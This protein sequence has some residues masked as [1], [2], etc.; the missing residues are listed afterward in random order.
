MTGSYGR[1]PMREEFARARSSYDDRPMSSGYGGPSSYSSSSYGS[2]YSSSSMGPRPPPRPFESRYGGGGGYGSGYG[3]GY[4]SSYGG[5]YGS[6]ACSPHRETFWRRAHLPSDYPSRYGS[7]MYGSGYGGGGMYGGSMYGGGG[8][9]NPYSRDPKYLM[10]EP[11]FPNAIET[12]FGWVNDFGRIV[13]TF[14]R[15]SWLLDMN[16]ET[17][18]ASSSHVLVILLGFTSSQIRLL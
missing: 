2:S 10:G 17:M 6:G 18:C 3:G 14:A 12:Q 8:M 15:I 16:L 1:P 13:D 7:S 5:G 11:G 4:G 9:L